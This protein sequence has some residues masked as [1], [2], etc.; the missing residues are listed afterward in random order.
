M[1]QPRR[2]V[3]TLRHQPAFGTWGWIA[4]NSIIG[5]NPLSLLD[6]LVADSLRQSRAECNHRRQQ[7][8]LN[9]DDLDER[10]RPPDVEGPTPVIQP[11]GF[12]Q[13]HQGGAH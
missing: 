8:G 1:Q 3:N 12:D 13:Q 4:V 7:T 10:I 9:Q 5:G 2:T 6:G 11:K